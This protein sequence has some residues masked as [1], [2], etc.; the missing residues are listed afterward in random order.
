MRILLDNWNND[1]FITVACFNLINGNTDRL[2][3]PMLLRLCSVARVND[4][5][6]ASFCLYMANTFMNLANISTN[7]Y[8]ALVAPYWFISQLYCIKNDVVF[9]LT[10]LCFLF[11]YTAAPDRSAPRGDRHVSGKAAAAVQ[12]QRLST[13]RGLRKFCFILF[14]C[15]M[16]KQ[17]TIEKW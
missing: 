3:S 6:P 7:L 10:V 12:H 17:N 1:I 16:T 5:G 15:S 14:N 8:H 9:L 4:A 11:A 2:L 13:G